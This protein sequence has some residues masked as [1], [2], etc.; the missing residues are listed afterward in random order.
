MK[1][2]PRQRRARSISMYNN[3]SAPTPAIVLTANGDVDQALPAG[4]AGGS[5]PGGLTDGSVPVSAE[6]ASA[7]GGFK[8]PQTAAQLAA[9]QQQQQQVAQVQKQVQEQQQQ[10]AAASAAAAARGST[11]SDSGGI[12][13]GAT[14]GGGGADGGPE[15]AVSA[16]CARASVYASLFRCVLVRGIVLGVK[17]VCCLSVC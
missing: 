11:S 5:T 7:A 2:R 17:R 16:L 1:S 9:Q 8:V 14:A 13:A 15:G 12:G 10:M 6:A 4:T 3:G